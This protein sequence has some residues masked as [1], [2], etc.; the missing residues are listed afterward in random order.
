MSPLIPRP[1]CLALVTLTLSCGSGG[2]SGSTADPGVAADAATAADS[3][4]AHDA[5]PAVDS[6]PDQGTA[7]GR[8]D[9]AWPVDQ[10][11]PFHAGFKEYSHTYEPEGK[12]GAAR[13]IR[14]AVWYP[15]DDTD[16]P[17]ARYFGAFDFDY[18]IAGA[19][20]A[21]PMVPSAGYPLHVHSH[22]HLGFAGASPWLLPYFATHGWVVAAPEHTGNTTK[23][24]DIPRRTD[25]FWLR[26]RDISATVDFLRD[27]PAGDPLSGLV[28]TERVVMSGHSFGG[29]TALVTC[30]AAFDMA[31]IEKECAA[32]T[33][34]GA[35]C[36][37]EDLAAFRGGVADPRMVACIAMAPGNRVMIAGRAGYAAIEVPVLH[38]TGSED[39][40]A[41]ND[42]VWADLQGADATR[43]DFAGGCHQLFGLG[44]CDQLSDALG[45]P[46]VNTY[47]FAFARK[48]LLGDGSVDGILDGSEKVSKLVT[49]FFARP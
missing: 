39:N 21:P 35:D 38:M 47:A 17:P 37:E 26:S 44:G 15:T 23:D 8:P 25:I 49:L 9:L 13:T 31:Y 36:T 1:L 33:G 45:L 40:P 43:V 28:N 4:A 20:L 42:A 16:G 22:G 41:N 5:A 32:G 7:P 2:S 3:S 6:G 11:G 27:L 48:H 12:G 19:A 18:A 24:F 14:I 46:L 10:P 29:Y 30:G 34:P